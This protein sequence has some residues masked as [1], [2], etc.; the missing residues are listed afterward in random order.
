MGCEGAQLG[1]LDV[2][3]VRMVFRDTECGGEFL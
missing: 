3:H 1:G 2:F